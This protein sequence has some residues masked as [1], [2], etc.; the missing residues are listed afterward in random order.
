MTEQDG[1]DNGSM[2]LACDTIINVMSN[3]N[4][5]IFWKFNSAYA[6]GKIDY[7]LVLL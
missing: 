7:L 2:F 1:I 6:M 4:D 5:F 3:V